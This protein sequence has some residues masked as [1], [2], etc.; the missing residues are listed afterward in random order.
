MHFLTRKYPGIFPTSKK[1]NQTPCLGGIDRPV[2][3]H[4]LHQST[5]WRYP[6]LKNPPSSVGNG[7]PLFQGNL[8]WWNLARIV[9]GDTVDGNQKSGINSPVEVGSWNPLIYTVFAP[10]QLVVWD[11]FHQQYPRKMWVLGGG[12]FF[13]ACIS[14]QPGLIWY[15]TW[16]FVYSFSVEVAKHP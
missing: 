2:F 7:T 15:L 12:M 3:V 11:F 4:F 10:S 5:W 6:S 13:P 1:K 8:G 14:I 16:D 9:W